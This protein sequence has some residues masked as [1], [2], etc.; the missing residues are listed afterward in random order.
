M[1]HATLPAPAARGNPP[2]N[3]EALAEPLGWYAIQTRSN[4]EKRVSAELTRKGCHAY[5]PV[6]RERHQWKDRKKIVEAPIFP[7]YVFVRCRNTREEQLGV[8]QT[9]GAVRILG[10][11][12]RPERIP[13]FQVEAVREMIGRGVPFYTY[14]RLPEGSAVRV[15]RGP[16]EGIEGVL[17]RV[18]NTHQLVVSIELLS[19]A[20][21]AE[22]DGADVEILPPQN[23][24]RAIGA[25]AS[26]ASR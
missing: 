23:G 8:L 24:S 25:Q 11:N 20:I 14:A 22:V 1:T 4:Y 9:T 15:R 21:A 16:L 18:K 17:L 7:G 5:L 6:S 19:Q 13:D 12:G 3:A 2:G 26:A 10:A